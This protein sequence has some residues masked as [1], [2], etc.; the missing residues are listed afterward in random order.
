M[1]IPHQSNP[2]SMNRIERRFVLPLIYSL[3]IEHK[4][5]L[6]TKSGVEA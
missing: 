1:H 5:K 4:E 3:V 2:L 6:L